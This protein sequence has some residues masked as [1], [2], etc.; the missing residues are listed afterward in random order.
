[1]KLSSKVKNKPQLITSMAAFSDIDI[2]TK[3]PNRRVMSKKKNN[4]PHQPKN[5]MKQRTLKT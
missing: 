1:M 2:Y 5:L 3:C 4:K